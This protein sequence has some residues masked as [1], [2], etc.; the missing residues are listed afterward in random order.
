MNALP[1]VTEPILLRSTLDVW[2]YYEGRRDSHPFSSP[3]R[4]A[5]V[6]P[7]ITL[8]VIGIETL[9]LRPRQ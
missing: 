6:L 8:Q 7:P 3:D 2:R 9:Q 1:T 4:S 5:V